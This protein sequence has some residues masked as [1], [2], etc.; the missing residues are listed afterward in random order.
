MLNGG[1]CSVYNAS[2]GVPH[3]QCIINHINLEKRF[4]VAGLD[5]VL[6]FPFEVIDDICNGETSKKEKD[7]SFMHAYAV[8][9]KSRKQTIIAH[10]ESDMMSGTFLPHDTTYILK[11]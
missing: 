1:T 11:R 9:N 8:F 4:E 10:K 2:V 3:I 6:W 7:I 5:L